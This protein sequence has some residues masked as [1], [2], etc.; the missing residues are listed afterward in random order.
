MTTATDWLK[1]ERRELAV[2]RILAAAREVFARLGGG[3]RDGLSAPAARRKY[4]EKMLIP[5]LVAG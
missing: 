5:A 1:E 3:L 4:L 2:D